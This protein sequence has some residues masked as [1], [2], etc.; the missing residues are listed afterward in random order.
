MWDRVSAASTV[1]SVPQRAPSHTPGQKH[2][3]TETWI[4]FFA[5]TQAYVC[6]K[7]R[8]LGSCSTLPGRG[9]YISL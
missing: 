2:A 6:C 4:L 8:A 7:R 9:V 5:Q 1:A 3:L